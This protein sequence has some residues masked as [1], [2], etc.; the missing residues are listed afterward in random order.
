MNRRILRVIPFSLFIFLLWAPLAHATSI[1]LVSVNGITDGSHMDGLVTLENMTTQAQ[2]PGLCWDFADNISV[3]N[4]FDATITP[5]LN[6]TPSSNL[7]KWE[8]IAWLYT[9]LPTNSADTIAIQ[10]AVWSIFGTGTPNGGSAETTWLNSAATAVTTGGF[11]SSPL[12]A[13]FSII[14]PNSGQTAGTYQGFIT[15]SVPTSGPEPMTLLLM[16]SGLLALGM[17]RRKRGRKS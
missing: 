14:Q 7:T 8:E 9:K 2:F 13:N 1:K 6:M 15:E 16:G 4:S 3:G 10:D 12:L 5:L 11:S 17:M